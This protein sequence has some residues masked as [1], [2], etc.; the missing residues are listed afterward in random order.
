LKIREYV[1]ADLTFLHE[2]NS[3]S[4]PGVSEETEE[5]LA[6][7]VSLSTCLVACDGADFPIGFITLI[8]PGT[9][10]Y[11]SPNLR[12]FEAHIESQPRKLIYV[13]RIA[14]HPD[15]RGR[16]LGERLYKAAYDAFE[17]Y[18]EIGCEVNLVPD[19]PPSHKFH[20]RMGFERIGE[21]V[22]SL[23]KAVA[24]YVREL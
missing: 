2:I 16:K 19:N 11:E 17:G 5:G 12:W 23:E 3:A 10:A 20:R 6:K 24:Y 13:D 7:I 8:K 18:D 1:E 15:H 4:T 22:F 14:L 21:Q 9:K